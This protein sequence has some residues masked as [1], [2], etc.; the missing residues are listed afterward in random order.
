MLKKIGHDIATMRPNGLA[1]TNLVFL[2]ERQGAGGGRDVEATLRSMDVTFRS[3]PLTIGSFEAETAGVAIERSSTE[4]AFANASA[5]PATFTLSGLADGIASA[6]I[7][8]YDDPSTD[9]TENT[10]AKETEATIS[11]AGTDA[12]IT[13]PPFAVARVVTKAPVPPADRG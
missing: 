3:Q 5:Q 7:G 6:E 13:V 2:N 1:G 12:I 10:W 11:A 4:F 9:V 8:S